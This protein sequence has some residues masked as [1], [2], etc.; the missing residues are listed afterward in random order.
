M[1]GPQKS[2]SWPS[3]VPKKCLTPSGHPVF[4]K[5]PCGDY[6]VPSSDK[7]EGKLC[8]DF[9]LL[10]CQETMPNIFS[11]I[12][13]WVLNSP[14]KLFNQQPIPSRFADTWQELFV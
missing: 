6:V 7:H 14:M 12:Q 9:S 3:I 8:L 4:L 13:I 5:L 11:M 2:C 1:G 10:I